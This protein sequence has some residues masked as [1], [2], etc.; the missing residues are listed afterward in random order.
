MGVQTVARALAI[1]PWV[2]NSGEKGMRLSIFNTR[3]A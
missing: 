1:L 3:S 2:G